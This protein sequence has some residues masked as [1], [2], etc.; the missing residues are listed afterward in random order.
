M[1]RWQRCLAL[2]NLLMWSL[3]PILN[4]YPAVLLLAAGLLVLLL[5]RPAQRPLARRQWWVL[6]GLRFAVILLVLLAMLRPTLVTSTKKA[7]SATLLLLLDQSRSMQL[8]QGTDQ[9]TRWQAQL[10]A[11]RKSES[12]L[13]ELVQSMEV[14]VYAFDTE[15]H[16]LAWEEGQPVMPAAP[17]GLRTDIGTSLDRAL[18]AAVGKRLAGVILLSDGTQTAFDPEVETQQAGRELARLG[19]PLYTVPLGPPGGVSQSR[20]VALKTLPVEYEV[21]VKNE[22][23]VEG[24]LEARGYGSQ[25]LPVRLVVKNLETGA[26]QTIGPIQVAANPDGQSVTAQIVHTPQEPGRYRLT[27]IADPQPGEL[28]TANNELAAFLR[29]LEGGLAVNYVYGN[30]VGEQLRLRRSLSASRDINL[31]HVYLPP[32]GIRGELDDPGNY[33]VVILE[34]VDASLL[35]EGYDL[36]LKQAVERQTGFLMIGGYHSFGPGGYQRTEL[37]DVLPIEMGRFERQ[38]LGVEQP[39]SRDL[40]LWGPLPLKLARTEDVTRLGPN[41]DNARLWESLPPLNGANRFAA[42]K[43]RARVLLETAA[44]DPLLVSGDYGGGR[45]VAFAGNTTWRWWED[46]EALHKRFWRQTVFWLAGREDQKKD[47]VWIVLQRRRFPVNS[48]VTFTAGANTQAGEPLID[49]RITASVTSPGGRQRVVT[50]SRDK[51]HWIGSFDFTEEIGDYTIQ[52]EA[53]DAAGQPL[54]TAS[55]PF[56]VFDH[57]MEL[58]IPTADH[59]Q[60]ARLSQQ[61]EAAG[62][63]LVAPEQLASL[64]DGILREPPEMEIEMQQAWQFPD[65]P[66]TAWSFFIVFVALLSGEWFLRKRWGLV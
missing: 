13:R 56:V 34:D 14:R 48:R 28:I 65:D 32:Q 3:H 21:Y 45:V 57:D 22:L 38:G 51:K 53:K 16:E 8:P 30:L 66:R 19:F 62:G 52:V 35:P 15:L 20:D 59:Q 27:L 47:D 5:V 46:H 11:L 37:A 60:L 24:Q 61:T 9:Q 4:S 42:V 58:G 33:D 36:E 31:Q 64:L 25:D 63:R 18:A 7:Q 12:Q 49:A 2:G 26:E 39:I 50:L 10:Q 23:L 55:M 43:P 40:H 44:G 1:C 17:E 6:R 41:R 54:G 29:V